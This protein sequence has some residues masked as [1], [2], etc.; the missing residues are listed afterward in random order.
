MNLAPRKRDEVRHLFPLA[1]FNL[2]MDTLASKTRKATERWCLYTERR[3]NL[4]RLSYVCLE[5]GTIFNTI[6][7]IKR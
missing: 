4:G 7:E 3:K 6:A 5:N 1:L 2:L